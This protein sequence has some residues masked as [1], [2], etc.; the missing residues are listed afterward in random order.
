LSVTRTTKAADEARSGDIEVVPSAGR[1]IRLAN[2]VRDRLQKKQ[3]VAEPKP[4]TPWHDKDRIMHRELTTAWTLSTSY[5]KRVINWYANPQES[6]RDQPWHSEE[7]LWPEH[8]RKEWTDIN[9]QRH[10][11]DEDPPE[12]LWDS[13]KGPLGRVAQPDLNFGHT[14]TKEELE[15][16]KLSKIEEAKW[17][18]ELKLGDVIHLEFEQGEYISTTTVAMEIYLG[19]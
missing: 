2:R 16:V 15:V 14:L 11:I 10:Y 13:L 3:I 9:D 5:Y 6:M 19:F 18:E 17:L 7:R 8:L 12:P 1:F 4:L